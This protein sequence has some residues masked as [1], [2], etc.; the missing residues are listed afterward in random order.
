VQ[1]F[2]EL[3]GLTISYQLQ[4]AKG[5]QSLEVSTA[6][7]EFSHPGI[8]IPIF[9]ICQLDTTESCLHLAHT[10]EMGISGALGK[11]KEVSSNLPFHMSAR[12]DLH[13]SKHPR[14]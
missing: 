9:C 6:V 2:A 3:R 7:I 11:M 12:N 13:Q 10:T 5:Q 4:M 8:L 14:I 1:T